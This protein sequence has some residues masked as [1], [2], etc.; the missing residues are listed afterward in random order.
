MEFPKLNQVEKEKEKRKRSLISLRKSIK[1]RKI[2]NREKL[3]N[4]I[5]TVRYNPNFLYFN[6]FY[7]TLFLF[8]RL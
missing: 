4:S 5:K 6:T 7:D 3:N 8:A 2:K 1:E